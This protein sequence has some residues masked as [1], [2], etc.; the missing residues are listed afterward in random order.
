VACSSVSFT[1]TFTFTFTCYSGQFLLKLELYRGILEKNQISSSIKIRPEGA[2][3]FHADGQTDGHADMTKLIV[4]FPNF[5]N[6]P[7]NN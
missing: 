4:A 6:A 1:F 2:E 5:A 3:F 7:I